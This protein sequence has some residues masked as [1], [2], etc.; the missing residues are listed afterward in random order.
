MKNT[1]GPVSAGEILQE[2]FLT[3]MHITAYRLAKEVH[4]PQSRISEIINGKRRITAD[5]AMRFSVFFGTTPE[6][7]LNIQNQYDLDELKISGKIVPINE[8]RPLSLMQG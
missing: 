3:P 6:F 2:E 7:W 5:T 4:I 8:I 1:L